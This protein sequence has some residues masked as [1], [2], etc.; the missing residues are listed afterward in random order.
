MVNDD[1]GLC[2]DCVLVALDVAAQAALGSLRVELGVVVDFLDEVEVTVDR[3]VVTEDVE[4]EAFLDG[5]LHGVAMERQVLDGVVWLRIWISEQ[6][7][8]L[9]LGRG[10]EREVAGVGEHPV[11]LNEAVYLVSKV[12][13]SS[14]SGWL[15]V[16]L[17]DALMAEAA[18]PPWLEWAS[19]MMIAKRRSRC[20]E[21][22]V[23]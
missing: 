8:C 9:V 6:F 21:L 3:G 18:R 12:S 14:S 23:L 11:A 20:S 19:S 22:I 10:R 5:L 4:D 1:F 13:L 2:A 7:E 16:L 15:L 17:R